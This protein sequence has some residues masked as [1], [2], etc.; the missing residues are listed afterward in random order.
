MRILTVTT[1]CVLLAT[2]LAQADD[3]TTTTQFHTYATVHSLGVEWHIAGDANHNATCAVRY[4]KVGDE[5]WRDAL[6]LLRVDYAWWWDK[7]LPG[8]PVNMLAGSVFFLHP[9]TPY[10]LRLALTDP[11][12]GSETKNV[13]IATRALPTR[14]TGGRMLHVSPGD[15]GGSGTA[16]DPFLG[17]PAAHDVAQA[18]DV[19]LIRSGHYPR[20][21]ITRGGKKD[22][23]YIAYVAAPGADMQVEQILVEADY[24]WFEG[25]HFEA[26][27]PDPAL[28]ARNGASDVVVYRNTFNGFHYSV[29]LHTDSRRWHIT[30]NT[31]VGDNP[32]DLQ[33]RESYSGEGVELRY[34]RDHVVAYNSITRVADGVSYPHTNCDIYGNDI[35]H[36]SDDGIEPDY[37]WANNRMWGNRITSPQWASLSF[38]PMKSGPWY[39]IRNQTIT[40]GVTLK[41]R[42]QD[43]FVLINNTFIRWGNGTGTHAGHHLLTAVSRN[44]LFI[45]AANDNAPMLSARDSKKPMYHV[46]NV[47]EP[48]WKTDLDYDGFDWG[49]APIAFRWNNHDLYPDL[50]SFVA[51][52]GIERHAIRVRKEQIF[53]RWDVPAEPTR[54]E[55]S[56]FTLRPGGNAIDAGQ[57]LP[58]VHFRITGDRP[59]LGAHELNAP[60]MHYGPRLDEATMRAHRLYWAQD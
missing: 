43:R 1:M 36:T 31:I 24:I 22:G 48:S 17:L 33:G 12:G 2:A 40:T 41:L 19:I 28:G 27:E 53:A 8:E 5:T 42:V 44:N 26:G 57:T 38:Q 3:A 50:P 52:V 32:P 56:V 55:R 37:G 30:D 49:D 46:P 45:N 59:D 51:A 20:M 9:D 34:S 23:G 11:D 25:L 4:R 54:V 21:K 39:F 60:P 58:N 16:D 10:E 7:D 14:P 18:N 6:P 29:A 13:N 15:G 35:F 47:Y